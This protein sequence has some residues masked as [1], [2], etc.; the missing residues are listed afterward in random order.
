VLSVDHCGR[1]GTKPRARVVVPKKAPYLRR[2]SGVIAGRCENASLTRTHNVAYS[3]NAT[4]DYGQTSRLCLEHGHAVRLID[5]RPNE[6][7]G[8]RIVCG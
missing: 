6:Y 1:C 4:G 2:Q 8:S 7:I 3:A 5:R